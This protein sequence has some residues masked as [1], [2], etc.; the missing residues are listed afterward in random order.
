MKSF[1]SLVP[2]LFTLVPKLSYLSS[3]DPSALM[4]WRPPGIGRAPREDAPV[5]VRRPPLS[6]AGVPALAANQRS[7][8]QG[9]DEQRNLSLQP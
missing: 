2:P 4:V 1:N 8:A 5:W 9:R 7:G 3:A 6:L